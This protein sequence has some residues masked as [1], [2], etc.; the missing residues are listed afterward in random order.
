MTILPVLDAAIRSQRQLD[1]LARLAADAERTVAELSRVVDIPSIR[2]MQADMQPSVD[3]ARRM[4]Q[5]IAASLPSKETLAQFP[6]VASESGCPGGV[7]EH[8]RRSAAAS[9]RSDADDRS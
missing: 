8:E 6:G 4:Q 7:P 1:G 5:E 9:L 2:R 3:L